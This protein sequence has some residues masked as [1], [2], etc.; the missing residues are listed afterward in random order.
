MDLKPRASIGD[1]RTHVSGIAFSRRGH[2]LDFSPE[3]ALSL[4]FKGRKRQTER[5]DPTQWGAVDTVFW[6]SSD[7]IFWGSSDTIFWGSSD[8][9]FWG[10]DT[11]LAGT[12]DENIS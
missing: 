7:T 4:H 1:D 12:G 5:L 8:T 10:S 3:A 6:G 11:I 9:I 2:S